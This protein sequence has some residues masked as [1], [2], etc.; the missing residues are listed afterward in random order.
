MVK[1]G[2][3]QDD[4]KTHNRALILK[5]IKQHPG[6]TRSNLA[7]L[8][9]LSKPAITKII[10]D[11]LSTGILV[12]DKEGESRN[13]GLAFKEG[14]F[15]AISIYLGRLSITGAL[16]DVA[17][18][19]VVREQLPKGITFYGND[20]LTYDAKG[21]IDTLIEK[22]GV[23][24]DK[25]L[26]VGIAAP[27]AIS[28]RSG[29]IF[30]RSVSFLGGDGNIP[31]NWGK[32]NLADFLEE[33]TG[34]PVFLEN[35]SNLS[36]L[37]E[38]WFGKGLDINNFVQYSVGLGIGAGA[39]ING[40]MMTGNDGISMEI[41]HTTV[42]FYGKLCFCGNRGCLETEAGFR[43][44]VEEYDKNDTI[45]DNESV[46]LRTA[47]IFQKAQQNEIYAVN[48]LREH[49]YRIASGAVSLINLF[50]PDKL[51]VSACDAEGVPL[52]LIMR[53]IEF[54]VRKHVYPVLT[55]S[56]K[57][58]YSELGEDIHLHGAYAL[59]LENLYPLMESKIES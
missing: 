50:S 4:S 2:L 58:E 53:D 41:G 13:K 22:S 33:S 20:N 51:I 12:E 1:A 10:N 11:F 23:N 38:S 35:N 6:V 26:A 36:A 3:N 17:G 44:L 16:Y 47:A 54:Y 18:N 21:L 28:N 52:H 43:K 19:V 55:D 46:I 32:I 37:A 15:F 30:N 14:L 40:E 56:I 7:V 5:Y 57:I 39:I 59:I 48:V 45:L 9:G 8:S 24:A 42:N 31:F 34:L 29:A 25:I 27:G 49:A